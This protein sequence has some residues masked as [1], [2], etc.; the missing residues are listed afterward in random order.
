MNGQAASRWHRVATVLQAVLMLEAA[1]YVLMYCVLAFYRLR[2]PYELEWIEGA[3]VDSCIRL[4][5]G[6]PVYTAPSIEFVPLIYNPLY[7]YVSAGAMLI[8]EGRAANIKERAELLDTAGMPANRR[9]S[10]VRTL[11]P[12]AE[13]IL[14]GKN[15]SNW[16][17]RSIKG[18]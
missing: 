9:N 16:F 18:S 13:V 10:V 3:V 5:H 8:N 4:A 11:T 6:L 7:L 12:F 1:G 15:S 2:Y 17:S 14:N